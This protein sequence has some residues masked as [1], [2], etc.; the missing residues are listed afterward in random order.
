MRPAPPTQFF[1][2]GGT[3]PPD[4]PSYVER[5]ADRELLHSVQ[6]GEFCYVL[7]TRQLGKSSLM[8]RTAQKLA[9]TA[10]VAIVD[11][12]DM[13]TIDEPGRWYY[14]VAH[15]IHSSLDAPIDLKS[16][17]ACQSA[18]S[19]TQQLSQFLAALLAAIREPI[20]SLSTRSTP[21]CGWPFPPTSLR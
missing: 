2:A 21:H 17:W 10:R 18:L 8:A 13:C 9:G 16:W 19:P 7:T 3:L 5:P 15:K 6:A 20:V 14:T 11:L 12:S 4:S 1:I